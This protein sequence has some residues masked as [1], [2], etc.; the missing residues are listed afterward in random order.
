MPSYVSDMNRNW[1]GKVP[2][3]IQLEQIGVDLRPELIFV[4]DDT[5]RSSQRLPSRIAEQN[6]RSQISK[7]E[8]L[9]EMS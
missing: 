6:F 8:C 1:T 5:M 9:N 7:G 3:D 4:V 2:V